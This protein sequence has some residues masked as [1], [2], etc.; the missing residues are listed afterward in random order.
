MV[1]RSFLDLSQ[2]GDLLRFE[3]PL[4]GSLAVLGVGLAT[5]RGACPSFDSWVTRLEGLP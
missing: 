1:R 4:L 5:I 3:K 2:C